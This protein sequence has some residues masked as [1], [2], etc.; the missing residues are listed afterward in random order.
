MPTTAPVSAVAQRVAELNKRARNEPEA[1]QDDAWAWIEELAARL[2]DPVVETELAELFAAGTPAD[3]DG[4]TFGILVGWTTVTGLDR[5]GAA[6][7]PVVKTALRAIGVP[8]IGK[9]FD[10]AQQ[11]GTNTMTRTADVLVR[12]F[13]QGYRLQKNGAYWEG[14]E[15]LNRVEQ[16]VVSPG[17]HVLVLDY[18]AGELGNPWPINRIRDEAVQ[19]VPGT[20]LG[21]KIW[22]QSDGY[23]QLAWWA[24]KSDVG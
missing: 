12:L 24:A 20:Y 14:F 11:R 7:L 13:G 6:L 8:W 4:Q 15:M 2:P 1:A 18:E 21:A 19:L 5:T 22:H 10:N 23:R 17:T 3:V 9:K 16:S